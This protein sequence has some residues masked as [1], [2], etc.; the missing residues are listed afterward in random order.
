MRTGLK[1]FL[2]FIFVSVAFSVQ[3]SA[4]T[5]NF[6]TCGA[7]GRYGP[8]QSQ[9]DSAYGQ[10]GPNVNIVG[11]GIQEWT[12]PEEGEYRI[13]AAGAQGANYRAQGGKGAIVKGEFNLDE[14]EKIK[15]LVGQEGEDPSKY[16]SGGSGGGGTFVVDSG[17]NPLIVAAGG[18]GANFGVPGR[19]GVGKDA[20]E[21]NINRDVDTHGNEHKGGAGGGFVGTAYSSN[22]G[23]A[24][25]NSPNCNGESFLDGGVGGVSNVDEYTEG[26]FG[27]GGAA[28]NWNSCA[29]G[30]GYRGGD[31]AD[32][33]SSCDDI[34][35]NYQD[36]VADY[37]YNSA[38]SYNSGESQSQQNGS[39]TGHG[40]LMIEL[41]ES[42]KTDFCNY[43][44][45]FNECVMNQTNE[46][47][48]WQ[49]NVS[50]V[51]ESRSNAVFEAFN[52]VAT[53][54]LTNSSRISG[55]WKGNIQI[56]SE[57]PRL[58][59]GA[60]FRPQGERIVIGE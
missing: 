48:D 38:L 14:G 10:E 2:L 30:G 21:L 54:N 26:G 28:S 11:E 22:A 27:G 3:A 58:K 13:K 53:L 36:T 57:S 33:R 44:G 15:I 50:S 39:N 55:L 7:E 1:I 16:Y 4:Q 35:D 19:P 37:N 49:Y 32:H 47:S 60:S 23:S 6:T 41:I 29:G 40:Y 18:G 31:A 43:R 24:C 42:N 51:F 59:T 17:D 12:V 52:G 56:R 8:S 9:C 45:P 25:E 20:R 34:Q 46:L 5:Y